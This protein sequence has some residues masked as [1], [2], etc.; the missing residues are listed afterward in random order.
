VK[1]GILINT[2]RHK[3]AIIGITNEAIKRGHQ[4]ILFFMD[5]GCLLLMDKEILSLRKLDDVSMSV[6]D[7]NRRKIG[8]KDEEILVGIRCGSQYDN[9]VMNKEADKVI[10]L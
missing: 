8:I 5:E 2:N 4:V 9:A 10:V 1:L 3:E 7:L 6:C